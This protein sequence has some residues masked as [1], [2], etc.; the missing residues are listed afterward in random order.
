[1]LPGGGGGCSSSSSSGGGGDCSSSS[2]GGD[3]SSSSGGGDYSSSGGSGGGGGTNS[4][5]SSLQ[6][7]PA[8]VGPFM[9][10]ANTIFI[11]IL[12]LRLGPP[13]SGN[14]N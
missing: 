4:V 2:G 12:E 3:C 1:M 7:A 9:A 14:N 6:V 10:C 13:H 8:T 5:M 11:S